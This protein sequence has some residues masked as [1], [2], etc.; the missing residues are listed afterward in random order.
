MANLEPQDAVFQL[1]NGTHLVGAGLTRTC[2]VFADVFKRGLDEK[3]IQPVSRD[4]VLI[5]L[6][7][8]FLDLINVGFSV[9]VGWDVIALI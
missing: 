5:R 1:L 2:L 6:T 7:D 9:K 3:Q 4:H 8:L